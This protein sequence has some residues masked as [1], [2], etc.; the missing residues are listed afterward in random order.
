ME[1]I[2]GHKITII[3]VDGHPAKIEIY[4]R[5]LKGVAAYSIYNSYNATEKRD[6]TEL[7]LTFSDIESFELVSTP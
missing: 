5:E 1:M 3:K 4:G 6:T 7:T 2:K